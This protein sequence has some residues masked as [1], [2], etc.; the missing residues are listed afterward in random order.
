MRPCLHTNRLGFRLWEPG[1][2]FIGLLPNAFQHGRS[3]RSVKHGSKDLAYPAKFAS[4][5]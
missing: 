5:R 4:A 2:E 3:Y 1:T